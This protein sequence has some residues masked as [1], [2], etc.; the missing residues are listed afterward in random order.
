MKDA[1]RGSSRHWADML[2]FK[3]ANNT[4]FICWYHY[5]C[6][7][8]NKLKAKVGPPSPK[9]YHSPVLSYI[10]S[11][12]LSVG[13]SMCVCVCLCVG[14]KQTSNIN[15]RQRQQ[16]RQGIRRTKATKHCQP[17]LFFIDIVSS[18]SKDTHT[19]GN[20]DTLNDL[21]SLNGNLPNLMSPFPINKREIFS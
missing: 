10:M 21:T 13:V 19:A 14:E 7:A 4:L 8:N 16:W 18:S 11:F 17:I 5:K 15:G 1:G 9:H 2:M 6:A 3:L 12:W 20:R